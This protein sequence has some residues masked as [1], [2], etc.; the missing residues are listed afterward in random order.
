MWRGGERDSCASD[1]NRL[2]SLPVGTRA[3][4]RLWNRELQKGMYTH[5]RGLA[6]SILIYVL[7]FENG[8]VRLREMK[9]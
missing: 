7:T 3:G 6:S 5:S 4:L 2:S 1:R 9:R 8:M